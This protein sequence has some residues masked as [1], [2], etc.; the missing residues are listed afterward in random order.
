MEIGRARLDRLAR[1]LGGKYARPIVMMNAGHR[2]WFR[3]PHGP[4]AAPIFL[5]AD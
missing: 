5:S 2:R 3:P 4:S 1:A